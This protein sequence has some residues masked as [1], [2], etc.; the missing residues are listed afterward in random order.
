M[1]DKVALITAASRGMGAAIAQELAAGGYRVA[2]LA[3]SDAVNALAAS[4]N[5]IAVQGSVTNADD[6]KRFVE[7]ALAHYGRMDAVV[8]NTGHPPKGDLLAIS[9]EAWH[10]GVDMLLMNV[11][12][13]ARLVTPTMQAQGGGAW[14]NISTF[15]AYEP[16]RAYPVSATIRAALGSFA[17]LYADEY[18]KDNIRMNNVLPGF[19]DSYPESDDNLARIPMARYGT[20]DEIAKTTAFLLSDGAAYITGQNIRVDGGITKSV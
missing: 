5:G 12:R 4:L 11:V 18:A 8:C 19:I 9:D 17:K 3:T 20:V 15:A 10:L 2:L 7:T 1:P 16:S 13:M 6:L 14:V